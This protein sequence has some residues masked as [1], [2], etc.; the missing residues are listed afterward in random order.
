MKTKMPNNKTRIKIKRY[1]KYK[2]ADVIL[3]FIFHIFLYTKRKMF[4]EEQQKRIE[5][6]LSKSN[7]MNFV[8]VPPALCNLICCYLLFNLDRKSELEINENL[9]FEWYKCLWWVSGGTSEFLMEI[10][11]ICTFFLIISYVWAL[12]TTLFSTQHLLNSS[13]AWNN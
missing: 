12:M 13:T 2:P 9:S 6:W 8:R 11:S 10:H 5:F 3:V 4:F 1:W 7:I